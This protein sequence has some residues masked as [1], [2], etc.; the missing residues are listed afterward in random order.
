MTGKCSRGDECSCRD[1]RLSLR[2]FC[3]HWTDDD[4][5]A[6]E[7][8][9]WSIENWKRL[10]EADRQRCLDHLRGWLPDDLLRVWRRQALEGKRIGSDRVRF[11]FDAGMQIRNRLRDVLPDEQL[12][13]IEGGCGHWDDFYY[14]ALDELVRG[15]A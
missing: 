11:H 2:M 7:I 15:V 12:P 13:R 5:P 10:P 6:G 4:E 8:E 1:Y 14:G 9:S 3:E